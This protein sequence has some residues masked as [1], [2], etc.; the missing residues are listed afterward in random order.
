MQKIKKK[1]GVLWNEL[2][3]KDMEEK[4]HFL[5]LINHAWELDGCDIF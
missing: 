2:E 5:D 4:V 1:N 3:P